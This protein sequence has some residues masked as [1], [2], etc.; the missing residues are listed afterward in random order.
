MIMMTM[1]MCDVLQECDVVPYHKIYVK[2]GGS[3]KMSILLQQHVWIGCSFA[4][5]VCSSKMF[6]V[7]DDV[8]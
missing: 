8:L 3:A 1:M 2:C 6:Q 5:Q 7:V 4:K